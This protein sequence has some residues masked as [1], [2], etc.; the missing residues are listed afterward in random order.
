MLS[1]RWIMA[2]HPKYPGDKCKPLI[3]ISNHKYG[4][5]RAYIKRKQEEKKS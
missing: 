2:M 5:A 4:V 3:E 1:E